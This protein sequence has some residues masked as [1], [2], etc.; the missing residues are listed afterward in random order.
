MTVFSTNPSLVDKLPGFVE[1]SPLDLTGVKDDLEVRLSLNLPNGVEV[2][3]DQTVLVQ[4][5]VAAIEGSVTLEN[6]PI[7][8]TDLPPDLMA[9]IS[10]ERWMSL[11][12][13]R[14][15]LLDKLI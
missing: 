4:V 5:G 13:A 7:R 1:T 3:G 14:C 15:R 11:F 6:L 9:R 2:V 12:L 10:P 8:V